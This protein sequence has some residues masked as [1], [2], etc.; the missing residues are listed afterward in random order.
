MISNWK[1]P[2]M[3]SALPVSSTAP[4]AGRETNSRSSISWRS[5]REKPPIAAVN[6]SP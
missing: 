4:I 3:P 2:N 6:S 1:K 5:S